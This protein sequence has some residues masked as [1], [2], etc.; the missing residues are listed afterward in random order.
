MGVPAGYPLTRGLLAG[1]S[2]RYGF[3]SVHVTFSSVAMGLLIP[4]MILVSMAGSA[5]P[6]RR[7]ARVSI[8]EVLRNE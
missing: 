1:L 8:V 6:V 5:I 7:A 3:G 4:L 2:E